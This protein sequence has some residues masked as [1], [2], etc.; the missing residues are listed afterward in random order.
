[1]VL[2]LLIYYKRN[3]IYV[4]N[5]TVGSN[6]K[7]TEIDKDHGKPRDNLFHPLLIASVIACQIY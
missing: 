7:T 6:S 4:M 5:T 1:M 2:K 3:T